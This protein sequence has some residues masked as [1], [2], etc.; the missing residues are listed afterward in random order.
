MKCQLEIT[1]YFHC[2]VEYLNLELKGQR[3]TG[4]SLPFLEP[5]FEVVASLRES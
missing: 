5:L 3:R 2:P 1:G 4:N